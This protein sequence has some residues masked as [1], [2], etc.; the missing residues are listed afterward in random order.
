[1]IFNKIFHFVK[2]YVIIELTGFNIERFLYICAKNEIKLFRIGKR[3]GNSLVLCMGIKDYKKIKSA[4]VMTD[5]KVRIKKR[6]G[7]PFFI[8]RIKKRSA[9][10]VLSL[11]FVALMF[12][13]S[14]FIWTI[15]ISGDNAQISQQIAN[16]LDIAGVKIGVYKPS[17]LDGEQIKSIILNNTDNVVWAW[18]YV[19]GTK[20]EVKYKEGIQAPV[21]IDKSKPC[22]IV[23]KK[24]A[25]IKSVLEKNGRARVFAGDT[26]LK[27]DLLIAGTIDSADSEIVKTVHSIGE[28][29]AYTW[30]EKSGE[31][32]LYKNVAR[33]TGN[34]KSFKTV[35]LF[36]K[37]FDLFASEDVGYSDYVIDER[38]SELKFGEDNYFGI[39]IYNKTYYETK[40]HKIEIPYEEAVKE[41][42]NDLEMRISKQLLPKSELVE[43]KVTHEKIDDETVKVSIMM[44][45][46]ESIGQ[47]VPLN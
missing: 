40:T 7:L 39:G 5:T 33:K 4:R 10:W 17:L 29:R 2:G 36:S 12:F 6:C 46:T 26:V 9:F 45:F 43:K 16:A 24:D 38:L 22:D 11:L 8:K 15:E 23:S 14:N 47:E 25:L 3:K 34:K 30:Y 27:G 41:G 28:I 31:Y 20:A 21:L 13:S 44:Q 19:K 32:K 37:C 35:K 42:I 18:M 1:M